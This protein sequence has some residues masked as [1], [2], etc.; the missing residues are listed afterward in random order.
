[1]GSTY[2]HQK[3]SLDL[4][5]FVDPLA[6]D[7]VVLQRLVETVT[8]G[9]LNDTRGEYLITKSSRLDRGDLSDVS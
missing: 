1:M 3:S 6:L 2:D 7:R 5:L 9:C 4:E 8:L